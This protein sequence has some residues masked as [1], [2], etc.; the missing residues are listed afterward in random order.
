M[1]PLQHLAPM[2]TLGF[3]AVQTT[4]KVVL[5]SVTTMPGALCVMT[6]GVLLM[7]TWP[8]DSLDSLPQVIISKSKVLGA[9]LSE[10]FNTV[11]VAGYAHIVEDQVYIYLAVVYLHCVH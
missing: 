8:A 1:F 11:S 9:R 3:E 2:V 4:M 10:Q 6:P 5:K 7:P